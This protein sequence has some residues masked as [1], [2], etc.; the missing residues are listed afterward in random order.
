MNEIDHSEHG[1]G[2]AYGEPDGSDCGCRATDHQSECAKAG[3]G[4]CSV[5]EKRKQAEL[6]GRTCGK[7]G[8][9]KPSTQIVW[10]SLKYYPCD[11]HYSEIKTLVDNE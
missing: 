2:D 6:K 4:F 11:D 9:G 5:A 8:C 7:V 10:G 3:C 1:R